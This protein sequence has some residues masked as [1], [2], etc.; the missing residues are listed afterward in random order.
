G[1]PI[2]V[3]A[4]RQGQ[5]AAAFFFPGTEAEIGGRRPS[6][7]KTYD[8]KIPNA[9][10]VDTVLSWLELAEPERPT[11]I[12]TYFSDV[13]HAGHE[14]GPDSEAVRQAVATVDQAVGRLVEG[15]KSRGLLERVNL[16][17]VSDHG[18]ARVDPSRV[19]LLDDYFDP[20]QAEMV[21]WSGTFVNIFSKPGPK[22]GPKPGLEQ[23]IYD[24]L[25]SKSPPH[26]SVY[27]KAEIPERFHYRESR[28]IG[29]IVVVAEEGWTISRR[30]R[31][32]PSTQ[33]RAAGAIYRGVHG[34]DNR[35]KS[36]RAIF[37]AHGP[38]FK[39]PLTI[40]PFANVDVYQ[41]L[42]GILGLKPAP[43]DGGTAT[44]RTVLR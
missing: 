32:R 13:D 28:R 42:T 33:T 11:M 23:S 22:P 35:L 17:I 26:V 27:R 4:E 43:N 38:A 12:L 29:E 44:A 6:Y 30:D 41:I 7:W 14:A 34:Y 19:V 25:K 10:R 31:D 8:E 9:E 20:Q 40:E 1:E 18:M 21:V 3:T 2:W 24:R 37:I 36:M 16:V 39:S 5:R 15:L